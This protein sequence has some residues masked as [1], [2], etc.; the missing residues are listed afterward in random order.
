MGRRKLVKVRNYEKAVTRLAS[1]KSIDV[2][3]DLGNEVTAAKY[4]TEITKFKK[5]LDAYNTALSTIDDLYNDCITQESVLKEWNER[6]LNG[7]G[8]KFGK[9][10]SQYEMAGGT[11]KSERKKQ[12]PKNPK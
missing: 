5:N 12:T 2:S 11:R 7:V 10:S 9:D 8:F 3:L 4:E 6:V 1:I